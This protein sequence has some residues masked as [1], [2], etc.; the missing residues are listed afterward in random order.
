MRQQGQY[1]SLCD[2]SRS[3]ELMPMPIHYISTEMASWAYHQFFIHH[4]PVEFKSLAR[5]ILYQSFLCKC[6][7][8]RKQGL[9]DTHTI[10]QKAILSEAPCVGLSECQIRRILRA[11][12]AK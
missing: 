9:K 12:G 1:S 3:L 11:K 2:I 5:N 4:K 6:L 8:L 10:I 7:D